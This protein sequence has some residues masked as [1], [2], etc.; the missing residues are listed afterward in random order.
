MYWNHFR[1]TRRV[2]L[3]PL[4]GYKLKNISYPNVFVYGSLDEQV[5]AQ[6]SSG[7]PGYDQK[8]HLD[9]LIIAIDAC[10]R[11]NG[12]C[13]GVYND[14]RGLKAGGRVRKDLPLLEIYLLR[15]LLISVVFMDMLVLQNTRLS[16]VSKWLILFLQG[17][18]YSFLKYFNSNK[19][20]N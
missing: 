1:A 8:N 7:N 17:I 9:P 15:E 12:T 16:L 3:G 10:F 4:I 6:K 19:L 2:S 14:R 11:K 18:N 13:P 5:Q 20:I